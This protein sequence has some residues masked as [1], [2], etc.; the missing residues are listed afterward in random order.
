MSMRFSQMTAT[1]LTMEIKQLEKEE[2]KALHDGETSQADILTQ[3]K[4]LAR[5]YLVDAKMIQSGQTY[6]VH[7][8]NTQFTVSYLNGIMAWGYWESSKQLVA[9]PIAKLKI[10][11]LHD[12]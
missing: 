7:E 5:S 10:S 9:I 2:A 4:W 6:Q 1:Q 11:E 12:D 3:K 8:E